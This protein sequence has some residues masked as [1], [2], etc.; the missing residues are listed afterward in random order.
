MD[1][2]AV[3]PCAQEYD[4]EADS[5]ELTRLIDAFQELEKRLDPAAATAAADP[6]PPCARDFRFKPRQSK[7]N[8]WTASCAPFTVFVIKLTTGDVK[9]LWPDGLVAVTSVPHGRTN[10]W[11]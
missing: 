3:P 10:V 7:G 11:R 9:S 2:F 8:T 6:R 5:L 4:R 1:A